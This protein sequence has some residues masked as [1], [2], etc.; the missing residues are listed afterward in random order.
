MPT[1][2]LV[3]E[4][5]TTMLVY[6]EQNNEEAIK[7]SLSENDSTMSKT[8]SAQPEYNDDKMQDQFELK[9]EVYILK[10]LMLFDSPK[11]NSWARVI[12]SVPS[13]PT[14]ADYWN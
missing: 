2:S 1:T 14:N 9:A 3:D 11:Q 10:S 6:G 8:T 5:E 4:S 12:T 13:R 7:F